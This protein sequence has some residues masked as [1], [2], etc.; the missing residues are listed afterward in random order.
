MKQCAEHNAK[1][2]KHRNECLHNEQKQI[3]WYRNAENRI[4]KS[5]MTPL[6]MHMRRCEI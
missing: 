6:K 4:E 2:W 3:D 5:E 1:C